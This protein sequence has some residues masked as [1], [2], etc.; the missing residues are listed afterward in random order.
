MKEHLIAFAVGM[1]VIMM[2]TS[3]VFALVI[4][5]GAEGLSIGLL[6]IIAWGVGMSIRNGVKHYHEDK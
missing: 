4:I 5:V 6:L 1:I 2:I 3:I